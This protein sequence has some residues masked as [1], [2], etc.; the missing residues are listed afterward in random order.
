MFLNGVVSLTEIKD[1]GSNHRNGY[2][3]SSVSMGGA[4]PE[5]ICR[6][7]LSF[8][9]GQKANMNDIIIFANV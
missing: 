5:I 7:N 8:I 9:H 6:S 3:L 1:P 4:K 2:C